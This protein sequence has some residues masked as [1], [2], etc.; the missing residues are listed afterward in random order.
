MCFLSSS[1]LKCHIQGIVCTRVNFKCARW[2]S[3]LLRPPASHSCLTRG[4][5]DFKNKCH[6]SNSGFS[7]LACA[8][9]YM[10][11]TSVSD[12]SCS[13]KL[14]GA[15]WN[16]VMRYAM[17]MSKQ[18]KKIQFGPFVAYFDRRRWIQIS[19]VCLRWMDV[20]FSDFYFAII[21]RGI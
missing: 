7:C 18:G 15:L 21:S 9:D 12:K 4:L 19:E 1:Y 14:W 8:V 3:L 2:N 17:R 11:L 5:H 13:T 6:M 20:G 10:I 16:R